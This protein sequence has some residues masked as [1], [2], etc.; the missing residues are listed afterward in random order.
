MNLKKTFFLSISTFF[1]VFIFSC[2]NNTSDEKIEENISIPE[3]NENATVIFENKSP[4]KIDIYKN[5]NPEKYDSDLLLLTLEPEKS[6]ELKLPESK[7]KELGDVFYIHYN[8]LLADKSE[9]GTKDIYVEAERFNI[10]NLTFVIKKGEKYKKIISTPLSDELR[11]FDAYIRIYNQHPKAI[12]ILNGSSLLENLSTEEVNLSPQKKGI[13]KLPIP[14]LSSSVEYAQLKIHDTNLGQ[15]FNIP[16]FN[17]ESGYIYDY[18]FIQEKEKSYIIFDKKQK[19][20]SVPTTKYLKT[21]LEDY[22]DALEYS[23]DLKNF[24]YSDTRLSW[25]DVKSQYPNSKAIVNG[26][27]YISVNNGFTLD[28]VYNPIESCGITCR[29]KDW[30]ITKISDSYLYAKIDT[31]SFNTMFNDFIKLNNGKLIILSTYLDS[32]NSGMFLYLLNSNLNLENELCI[33]GNNSTSYIGSNLCP[34]D[35]EGFLLVGEQRNYEIEKGSEEKKIVSTNIFVQKY[36]GTQQKEW[37]KQYSYKTENNEFIF[38]SGIQAIESNSNFILCGD[39]SNKNRLKT[40]ILKIDKTNG[41][42]LSIKSFGNGVNDFT[43]FSITC[44]EEK[45]IY[46]TGLVSENDFSF[47]S[48]I[49]KLDSDFNEI[50]QKKYGTKNNDFLFNL[51]VKENSIIAVGSEN[52]LLTSDSNYYPWQEKSKGW[53]LKIDKESGIILNNIYSDKVS[54]FNTI[55]NTDD[56]GFLISAVKN[57]NKEKLYSFKTLIVKTNENLEF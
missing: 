13:Y 8:I 17:A 52:S 22:S 51:I 33:P 32:K 18:F 56:D 1:L 39:A 46:I 50:W 49:L 6:K 40:I 10:S 20:K 29:D 48:F 34:T 45:N 31:K 41:E 38:N 36:S 53:I 43:P 11:F 47:N 23:E 26:E 28:E 44:D 2:T 7:N 27:D 3:N 16:N 19:I 9:T 24:M 35:D 30:N 4:H 14:A 42:L 54:S 57:M 12:R 5:I 25:S 15:T 55:T 37:E 21:A